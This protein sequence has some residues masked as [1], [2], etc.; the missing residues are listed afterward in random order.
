MNG[1]IIAAV[2]LLIIMAAV[3][4]Y[5]N[6]SKVPAKSAS[7]T[8]PTTTPAAPAAPTTTPAAPPPAAP[9]RIPATVLS[10]QPPPHC[11]KCDTSCVSGDCTYGCS[12]GIEQAYAPSIA[13]NRRPA[14]TPIIIRDYRM[15]DASNP[16]PDININGYPYWYDQDYTV[17]ACPAK[18]AGTY[19]V[20]TTTNS[21]G[22]GTMSTEVCEPGCWPGECKY[23]PTKKHIT[24]NLPPFSNMSWLC[25]P[26]PGD[27]RCQQYNTT[28]KMVGPGWNVESI[29][30]MAGGTL[31][32]VG[33]YKGN[34]YFT[35]YP[36]HSPDTKFAYKYGD[37]WTNL[38]SSCASEPVR[39]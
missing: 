12:K 7:T 24:G 37:N 4:Y 26:N 19:N 28:I 32:N 6:K 18:Y 31:H 3:Y 39:T 2:V 17:S 21:Y 9:T 25:D 23:V 34:V 20:M 36:M 11:H 16:N 10:T 13:A 29:K 30:N 15:S 22:P 8:T 14:G 1:I 5:K 35:D 38:D 27:P 33:E